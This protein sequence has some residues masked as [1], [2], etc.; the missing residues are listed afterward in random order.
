[1]FILTL[2][3]DQTYKLG[4]VNKIVYLLDSRFLLWRFRISKDHHLCYRE[5]TSSFMVAKVSLL[6]PLCTL[7]FFLRF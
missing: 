7:A 2:H 6:D 5:T 4:L 1:M 3:K